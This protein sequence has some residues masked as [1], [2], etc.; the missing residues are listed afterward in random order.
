[1]VEVKLMEV[2]AVEVVEVELM[3][4]VKVKV[5]EVKVMEVVEVVCAHVHSCTYLCARELPGS[6][7]AS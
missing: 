3:E 2:V 5:V 7:P 6:V 1:M 4:E